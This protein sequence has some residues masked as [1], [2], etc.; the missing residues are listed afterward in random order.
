MRFLVKVSVLR[1]R[2][3]TI[4]ASISKV[5]LLLAQV[6]TRRLKAKS[7]LAD[8]KLGVDWSAIPRINKNLSASVRRIILLSERR[9]DDLSPE[10]K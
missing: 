8:K 1:A 6:C 2:N 10:R 9:P 4:G 7:V 3:A 5:L